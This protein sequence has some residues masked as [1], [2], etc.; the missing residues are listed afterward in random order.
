[1][2]RIVIVDDHQVVVDSLQF[3]VEHEQQHQVVAKF[4]NGLSFIDALK[5]GDLLFEILILDIQLPDIIGIEVAKRLREDFPEIKIVLLSQH[6]NKDFVL[7]GLREGALAYL[8]KNCTG[9]ELLLAIDTVSKDQVFMSQEIASIVVNSKS[10]GKITFQLTERELEVLKLIVLGFSNKQIAKKLFIEATGVEY[11]KRN[12]RE[13][14]NVTK[15]VELAVKAI[16]L[17]F[18]TLN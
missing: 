11:H 10:T 17:G 3:L 5:K 18:V 1:M 7:S 13:K 12:L 2:A 9:E 15:T 14:L 6:K 4:Y 8:L 16:E